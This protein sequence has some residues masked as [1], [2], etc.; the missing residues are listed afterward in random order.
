MDMAH[1]RE[2]IAAH[3]GSAKVPG[4]IRVLSDT[5]DFFQVDYDDVLLLEGRTLFIRHSE[6]EGRFG[7]DDQPKF[8]VR[9]AVD[10]E[11]GS[12]KVIKMVFHERFTANCGALTY[13]CVRSSIKEAHILDIVEGHP[14]FMQGV[15]MHDSAGNCV[16]VMD[17]I[18]GVS[19]PQYVSDLCKDHEEYYFKHLP[20]LL[21]E[22]VELVEAIRFLHAHDQIHGD[23]RRDH[24]IR[25]KD[26]HICKWIDF[27]YS[28]FHPENQYVYDMAG[29]ANI[30]VFLAGADDV[31][32]QQLE[33]DR[34]EVLGALDAGDMN[35]IFRNRVA[36]LKKVYPYISDDLNYMLLH[37]SVGARLF[38]E[39][40]G[41]FIEDL[42]LVLEGMRAS[43]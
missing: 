27:D 10:L 25:E 19:Y 15:S 20:G 7:I 43:Q 35:M 40:T 5:S 21:E 32:V 13:E 12:L 8:W 34:P 17:Y 33:R 3:L 14:R 41:Q 38:Y 23:I 4:R 26:T 24:I 6:H 18:L 11:D 9:R 31:T 30:L 36:N 2:K 1:L 39:D 22:F 42:G 28:C 37:I 29:L 16:R